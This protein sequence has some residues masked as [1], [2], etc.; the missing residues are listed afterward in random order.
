MDSASPSRM[1]GESNGDHWFQ[2]R[3]L[4]WE[5]SV[6]P[7]E[8]EQ[9]KRRNGTTISLDPW[10]R[11]RVLQACGASHKDAVAQPSTMG[12]SVAAKSIGSKKQGG[13]GLEVHS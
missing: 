13:C 7:V 5:H 8:I 2:P 1:D 10:L 6:L 11:C 4:Q 3:I 9:M 12:S